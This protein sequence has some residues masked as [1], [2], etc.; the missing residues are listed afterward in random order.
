MSLTIYCKQE[1]VSPRRPIKIPRSSP[2][3]S[4]AIEAVV[5]VSPPS[6]G[7]VQGITEAS[8]PILPRSVSKTLLAASA[9]SLSFSGIGT[10][11]LT[12]ILASSAPRPRMPVLPSLRTVT[13]T[14][15]RLTP[16]CS[17]AWW[18]AASTLLALISTSSIISRLLC[19]TRLYNI[20]LSRSP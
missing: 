17:K 3:I 2:F 15:S 18:I 6:G 8:T 4:K 13:S 1:S 12:L 10:N 19:S 16:N 20:S 5:T 11:G 9:I 7:W 14:S